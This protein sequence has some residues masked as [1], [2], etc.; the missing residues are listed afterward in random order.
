MGSIIECLVL[1]R[2]TLLARPVILLYLE[3][4]Q[5]KQ[6]LGLKIEIGYHLDAGYL[7]FGWVAEMGGA[8]EAALKYPNS[9]H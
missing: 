9:Q 3:Q 4:S 7:I 5:N 6:K 8:P 2:M 1:L